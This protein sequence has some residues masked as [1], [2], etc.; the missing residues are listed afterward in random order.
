M[1]SF[2]APLLNISTEGELQREIKDVIDE[3]DIM[4]YINNQQLEV[5]KKFAKDVGDLLNP[6]GDG[7]RFNASSPPTSPTASSAEQREAKHTKRSSNYSWFRRTAQE[8]L[9]DVEDRIKELNGL[10]QS[11]ESTSKSVSSL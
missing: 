2:V 11:A 7:R 9:D 5:M 4:I 3:L 8:L 1:S 10:K 6:D